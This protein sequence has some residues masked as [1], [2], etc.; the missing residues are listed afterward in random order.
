M[1]N[2]GFNV[3]GTDQASA[4]GLKSSAAH[5]GLRCRRPGGRCTH[6]SA[7]AGNADAAGQLRTLGV[8]RPIVK[9][10]AEPILSLLGR[11]GPIQSSIPSRWQHNQVPAWRPVPPEAARPVRSPASAL[12]Y[13]GR[14]SEAIR[15]THNESANSAL[16]RENCLAQKVRENSSSDC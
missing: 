2:I 12:P 10:L 11:A 5:D 6:S 13:S 14:V 15:P 3:F 7:S 1:V 16:E 8:T 9:S 4:T